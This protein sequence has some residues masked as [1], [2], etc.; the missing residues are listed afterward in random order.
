[1]SRIIQSVALLVNFLE[2]AYDKKAWHGTTLRGSLRNVALKEALWRPSPKHHNIWE[3]VL[4]TAYWKYIVRRKLGRLAEEE[5]PRK[6][7]DWPF[8]PDKT[9]IKA[10]RSDIA[11]LKNQHLLLI[12]AL[13]KL[14]DNK[15]ETNAPDSKLKYESYILGIGS[16]DLYHAGQIQLLK[17]LQRGGVAKVRIR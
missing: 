9:D 10:W 16:H 2:Q 6:G 5:F 7:S 3:I 1:M 14:P 11:I 13:K 15:I 4:H 17:R 8:L 12:E